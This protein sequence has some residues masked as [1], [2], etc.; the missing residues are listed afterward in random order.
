[1]GEL[2][3]GF[4]PVDDV[5]VEVVPAGAAVEDEG[6]DSDERGHGNEDQGPAVSGHGF[7]VPRCGVMVKKRRSFDS[8]NGDET[9]IG[10]AQD[11]TFLGLGI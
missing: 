8:A 3:G 11:D 5:E 1:V 10:F 2:A 6:C 9:A 4:E 7:R